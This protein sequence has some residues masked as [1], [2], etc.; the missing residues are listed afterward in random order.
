VCIVL[1]HG[2]AGCE[3]RTSTASGSPAPSS[4]SKLPAPKLDTPS[5]APRSTALLPSRLAELT[6][7]E[8]EKSGELERTLASLPGVAE[9]RVHL[10]YPTPAP[11]LGDT[12]AQP[13]KASV[14]LQHRTPDAPLLVSDVQ[15]LVAGGTR[16]I[17][18][19]DVQVILQR[20][21]SATPPASYQPVA[22]LV[23]IGPISVEKDSARLARVV[24]GVA[25]L[26]GLTLTAVLLG[27]WLTLRRRS[28]STMTAP[29]S[30]D[31]RRP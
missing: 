6:Q 16:G 24:L 18:S 2:V 25:T 30:P 8:H 13:G 27:M 12:P 17:A 15:R 23:R 22:E 11:L 26:T 29:R 4:A 1:A 14:L 28:A 7:L 21:P 9:A 10:V 31:F 19:Q 3:T 20:V 5:A